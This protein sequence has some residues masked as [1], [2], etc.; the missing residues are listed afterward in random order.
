MQYIIFTIVDESSNAPFN[1]QFR[2]LLFPFGNMGDHQ[3]TLE[4]PQEK[5]EKNA[6]SYQ[7][8]PEQNASSWKG[9]LFKTAL[10]GAGV[11]V[12]AG[13]AYAGY[14]QGFFDGASGMFDTMKE[15]FEQAPTCEAFDSDTAVDLGL[16]STLSTQVGEDVCDN[17]VNFEA[18]KKYFMEKAAEKNPL[19]NVDVLN[20]NT[21]AMGETVSSYMKTAQDFV[22]EP[23]TGAYDE[24]K[25]GLFW[26]TVTPAASIS[27]VLFTAAQCLNAAK[28]FRR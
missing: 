1:P 13:A 16:N 27:L 17:T 14:R 15:H 5:L 26:G 25:N 2:D 11:A 3:I 19:M 21:T 6:S 10:V 28:G 18:A 9:T 8:K 22:T 23:F 12:I 24:L 20:V 4:A 7:E